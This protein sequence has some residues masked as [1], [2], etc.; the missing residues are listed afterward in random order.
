MPH[1]EKK[2]YTREKEVPAGEVGGDE[3]SYSDS[4]IVIVFLN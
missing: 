3:A 4:T 2:D 1:K